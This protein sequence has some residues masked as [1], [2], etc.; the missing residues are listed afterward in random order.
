MRVLRIA[1]RLSLRDA[2]MI[3]GINSSTL[4]Q[5]KALSAECDETVVCAEQDVDEE[6]SSTEIDEETMA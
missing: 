1:R 4:S 5:Y 6:V 3:T 2:T